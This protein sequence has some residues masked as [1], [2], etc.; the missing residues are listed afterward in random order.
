[1]TRAWVEKPA[2]LLRVGDVLLPFRRRVTGV[3]IDLEPAVR[4]TAE[5]ARRPILFRADTTVRVERD[6]DKADAS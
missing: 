1:M 4:V 2:R 3:L 6:P 5:G